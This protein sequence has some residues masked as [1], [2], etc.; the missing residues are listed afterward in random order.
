MKINMTSKDGVTLLT[1]GKYCTEDIEV[2]PTFETGGGSDNVVEVN[3]LPTENI[4]ESKI[5]VVNKVSDIEVY[6]CYGDGYMSLAEAVAS[7]IGATPTIYYEIVSE[8][9]ASP[10]ATDL[11]AFNPIYCYIYNNVA[12]VY[13]NAGSG[14][15]WLTVS[16]L[17]AQMGEAVEDKGRTYDIEL[18]TEAGLYVYWVDRAVGTPIVDESF[19]LRNSQWINNTRYRTLFLRQATEL[20]EDDFQGIKSIPLGFQAYSSFLKNAIIPSGVTAINDEAFYGCSNLESV[21]IGKDVVGLGGNAI[22]YVPP[23]GECDS[24]QEFI[25]DENNQRFSSVDGVLYSKTKT[26][27]YRYPAGKEESA[28]VL[29]E[30][31]NTINT[32]AFFSCKKL[33]SVELSNNITSIPHYAFYSCTGLTSII[34]PNSVKS[35]NESAFGNCDSLKEIILPNSVLSLDKQAF[36]GSGLEKI[37]LSDFTGRL[38]EEV[39]GYCYSLHTIVFGIYIKFIGRKAFEYCSSLQLVDC[40]KAISIPF[41]DELAFTAA[42]DTYKI[43]VPDALYDEWIAAENWTEYASHIIKASEYTE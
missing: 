9:P 15:T 27:L 17:F 40:R 33:T 32:G 18:E 14:N 13:G 12:Y 36:R 10:T 23:F 42:S 8:L 6:Y 35:I 34:I 30:S 41:L 39:F 43:V 20:T 19:S 21:V 16:A 1:K 22:G 25:V 26:M 24:L 37:V 28:F 7:S 31:V 5:Y 38:S 3:E 4:D 29:P 2:K 11:Q